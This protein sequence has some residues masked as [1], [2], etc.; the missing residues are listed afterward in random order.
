MPFNNRSPYLITSRKFPSDPAQLEPTLNKM[1][2]E[3]AAA[4][5]ARTVGL[6]NMSQI[7]TGNI[8]FND[9]DPQ[10]QHP[11]FRRVYQLA[12]IASGTNTI[13]LGFTPT[14]TTRF[15]NMYGTGNS[16]SVQSVAIP[17]VNVTTPTDGI[18]LRVNWGTSNIE[19]VTT[20]GNWTAYSA[21][22]VLEYILN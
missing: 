13:P 19:V 17:H 9:G 20:T 22:I 1:Y 8:Y 4:V 3:V 14:S 11:G 12:S 2:I 15:V 16:P 18:E 6:Y 21:I 10:D 7:T 5:N